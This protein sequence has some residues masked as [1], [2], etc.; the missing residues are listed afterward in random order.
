LVKATILAHPKFAQVKANYPNLE[1]GV[2]ALETQY[3][4]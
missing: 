1:A 2:A 4:V 3:P